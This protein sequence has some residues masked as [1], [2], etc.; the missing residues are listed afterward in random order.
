MRRVAFIIAA[1]IVSDFLVFIVAGPSMIDVN[2]VAIAHA[3]A[4]Q[5]DNPSPE[6]QRVL[7]A[8]AHKAAVIRMEVGVA[9]SIV[10]LIITSGGFFLAGRQWERRRSARSDPRDLYESHANT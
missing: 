5:H 10:I 2:M 4:A 1:V 9:G 8:A 7:D 6:N 3:I